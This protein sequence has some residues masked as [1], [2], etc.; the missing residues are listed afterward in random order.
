MTE[1]SDEDS[2]RDLCYEHVERVFDCHSDAVRKRLGCE[3]VERALTWCVLSSF[4]PEEAQRLKSCM[5]ITGSLH[6][7]KPISPSCR[8]AFVK[9]AFFVAAVGVSRFTH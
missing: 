8:W 3:P 6:M 1:L 4:C 5:E 7:R 9:V 2:S